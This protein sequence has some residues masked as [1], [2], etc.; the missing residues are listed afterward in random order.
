[1]KREDYSN[2]MSGMFLGWINKNAALM[3]EA[4]IAEG[5]AIIITF[6]LADKY[7]KEPYARRNRSA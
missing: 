1:V 6:R 4:R 3:L 7:G 5:R 2:V